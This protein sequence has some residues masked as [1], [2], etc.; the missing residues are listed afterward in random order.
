MTYGTSNGGGHSPLSDLSA[1]PVLTEVV[2]ARGRGGPSPVSGG[3]LG[4]LVSGTLRQ[5]LGWKPDE[6]DPGGFGAALN[7]AFELREVDGHI[8]SR[9]LERNY[10]VQVRSDMGAVTGAQASIFSRAQAALDH[11]LPL[12]AGLKPLRMDADPQDCE[13]VRSLVRGELQSLVAEMGQAGGPRVQRVESLFVQ[14]LGPESKDSSARQPGGHL[15]TLQAR[16]G[17]DSRR[18][19]TLDEEVALTNFIIVADH[20]YGMQRSWADQ[21]HSFD[22]AG[23]DSFLGTELLLLSRTLAVVAESVDE[24]RYSMDSVFLGDAQRQTLTLMLPARTIRL[25]VIPLRQQGGQTVTEQKRVTRNP[26]RSDPSMYVAELLDWVETVAV[27]EGPRIIQDAGKDGVTSFMYTLDRLRRYVRAALSSENG[28]LQSAD[29][30]PAGYG[31]PRVQRAIQEL[32]TQLDDATDHAARVGRGQPPK[33]RRIMVNVGFQEDGQ[34]QL[35]L[36][37]LGEHFQQG[38]TVRL[39]SGTDGDLYLR[40]GPDHVDWQNNGMLSVTVS[41]GDL[42]KA[43]RG[44]KGERSWSLMVTNPD[45]LSS[46]PVFALA[47]NTA[48]LGGAFGGGAGSGGPNGRNSGTGGAV[49]DLS[50]IEDDLAVTDDTVTD[51]DTPE[52]EN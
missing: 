27:R 28:G 51:N 6:R 18:V 12:L 29:R 21:R 36:L 2:G 23:Q 4:E 43:A 11:A 25:P 52:E 14:L 41:P 32:A 40:R 37:I 38:A 35:V 48:G 46:E 13:A 33:V 10:A 17:L 9:Y 24:V 1:F 45:E 44:D 34:P 20:A 22:R 30:L 49:D 50:D 8:E 31:T 47:W 16:F 39:I 26:V 3:E 7:G 19:N 5:L 15:K 42:L